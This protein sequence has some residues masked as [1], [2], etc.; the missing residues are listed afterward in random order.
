MVVK[1]RKPESAGCM[2]MGSHCTGVRIEAG[3]SSNAVECAGG[4]MWK[5]IAEVK[6]GR[7][8]QVFFEVV[9]EIVFWLSSQRS[10]IAPFSEQGAHTL[11]RRFGGGLLVRGHCFAVAAISR[12]VLEP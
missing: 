4:C 3:M 11:A 5:D 9:E 2:A 12:S 7:D 10:W 1:R 8:V 6:C